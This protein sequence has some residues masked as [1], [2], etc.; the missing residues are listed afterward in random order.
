MLYLMKLALRNVGRNRRRSLL[1]CISVGIS[2]MV[3]VFLQGWMSGIMESFVKNSTKNDTGHL[4][5]ATKKFEEKYRFLPVTDN[6]RDPQKIIAMIE[7]DKRIA[8]KIALITERISFGVLLSRGPNAKSAMALA[9]DPEKEKRLLL[10]QKSIVPGG[11]YIEGPRELI[12]GSSLAK[13]LKYRVGDTVRVM[14]SGSDWALH[15]K[16]FVVVGL[17]KTGLLGLDDMV[18]QIRLDDAR[19]LLRMEDEAQQVVVMLRDYR[20]ADNVAGYLRAK[21]SDTTLSVTSWT[22]IGDTYATIRLIGN[23]YNWIFVIIALLGAFIISNIMMMVVMERRKEIGILKSM[24]VSGRE[25]LFM[26]LT[27]GALL[28]FAGSLAGAVLGFAFVVA[29]HFHGI[30]MTAF[31]SRV[32]LPLDNVIYPRL[33]IVNLVK[34]IGLGVILA[35]GVSLLPARQAARMNAVDAIKSV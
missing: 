28:G 19:D 18:F 17:F 11:R 16:K 24:G 32:D 10:L 15:L 7:N 23:V 6:V 8:G 9:G 21:I 26:F 14:T 12:M 1:A 29:L 20:E 5:I 13:S 33:S 30:D 3:I 34:S 25:V 27:E 22:K 2:L 35:A 31:M 4:R